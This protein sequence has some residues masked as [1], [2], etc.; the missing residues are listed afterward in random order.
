MYGLWNFF[1]SRRA[2]TIFTMVTLLATGVYSLFAIPKESNPEVVIPIGVV[3]TILPGATAADIEELVTNTLEP[4]VRNVANI[5]KVT[6]VSR[7]GVSVITAQFLASADI[8]TSVQDL[9]NAVE[10]A[11]RDLP[12]DAEVPT[13]TK[14]DFQNQPVLMLGIG[15]DLAPESLTELGQ[16]LKDDLISIPGVSRVE[17]SGTRAREVTVIVRKEKLIEHN[18]RVE[19]IISAIRS[20]NASA[21][22]G[23]ITVEGVEYPIQFEGSVT[24]P[25]LIGTTPI[26]T[27]TGEVTLNEVAT[28]IDG[29]EKSET[30]SRI[31]LAGQESQFALSLFIY[32]S[33]GGSILE[34]SDR[35]KERLEELEQTTLAGSRAVITYDAAE[36]VRTSISELTTSG[37]QTILLVLIVLFVAIGFKDAVV[38]ALS[39]PFSFMIAFIGMLATGN[40]INFI[41]LFSL[42]IAIGILVDSGIVVVEG[43]HTNRANGM[44]RYSAARKVLKDFGWP[45]IAGTAT[46][47]A[48]FVPLFFLSGIIGQFVKSIPFTIVVVL[49][50][51]IVVAL[52]FVPSIALHLIKHEE[53]PFAKKRERLWSVIGA[54]YRR[55]MDKFF[56]SRKQQRVFY[57]FLAV[58]LIGAFMLPISGLLKVAMFPPSDFDLFYVEIE[59][60]QAT[61]L[62]ETDR[63]AQ[64]IETILADTPFLESLVTTVGATSAFNSNGSGGGSKFANITVNLEKERNGITS[65]ALT[66]SLRDKLRREDFGNAIVS[67]FD[68]EG[69]PPSGAPIVAK[70]WGETLEEIALAVEQIERT[71][72]TTEGTRDITS[73]LSNDGTEIVIDIDRQKAN[74]YGLATSDIASTLRAAISGSEATKIRSDGDDIEVRVVFDLNSDFVKPEDTTRASAED[75]RAIPISTPRGVVPLG[76]LTTI[77]AGRTSASINHENGTRV[78]S[79]SSY[80]LE[81]AN[82]VEVTSAVRNSVDKLELPEGVRVTFGGEDEEIKQT[83]TEMLLALIAGLVLMF[84]ILVLEF[85][86]FTRSLRLLAA[87]PLSLTGVLWG[88]FI[89]GQPLSF[90]AF[91]GIIALAGVI[92]NHGILLLDAMNQRQKEFPNITPEKLVLDTA[93]SRL[94]PILLTTLTTVVGMAP[95]TFVSAMWAPLAFTIAFGLLYGTLLTLVFIPLLSYRREMKYLKKKHA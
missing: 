55:R 73:S 17:V 53:S 28:V 95:L 6:S 45:L 46:T 38:A 50:A 74:E 15:T 33:S 18:L 79:V 66:D 40:T 86:T 10:A 3:T 37:I 13:V 19:Q 65:L 52:A 71:V 91:L 43:I 24:D 87:I 81:G 51:S 94:R 90:T 59:L 62:T 20:T 63:V 76:S 23:S 68:A 12:S 25:A 75:I 1:L 29:Y 56:A 21:P 44:D 32:K 58:S 34:V 41:S 4:A 14:V 26:K 85:D 89:A 35:I 84:A 78:G 8:E 47:I 22:A 27:A 5:D 30:I 54:W 11:R 42:I 64:R 80:V 67:V 48:V 9:R 82:V 36:E 93:E 61:T 77:S 88:L 72:E 83:F 39:I 92:I 31:L 69:G 7:P 2:F 49:A 60:P 57:A 16:Q 70:V